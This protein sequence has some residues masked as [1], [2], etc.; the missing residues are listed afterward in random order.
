MSGFFIL[1]MICLASSDI[2]VYSAAC[3][4]LLLFFANCEMS[5]PETNALSPAPFIT[6][7]RM[8]SSAS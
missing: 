8:S 6:T 1:I 2:R 5:A 4:A 7:T 3:S